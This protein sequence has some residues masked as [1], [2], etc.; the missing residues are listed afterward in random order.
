DAVD[1]PDAAHQTVTVDGDVG[2]E[3][4]PIADLDV[5]HRPAQPRRPRQRPVRRLRSD[6]PRQVDGRSDTAAGAKADP[7]AAPGAA[8]FATATLAAT[9]RCLETAA[10]HR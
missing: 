3:Q 10:A 1:Q 8:A 2:H 5:A 7:L 9:G 6:E 4:R